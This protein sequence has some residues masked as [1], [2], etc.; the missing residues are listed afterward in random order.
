MSHYCR[1]C[2]ALK[3]QIEIKDEV[4]RSKDERIIRLQ[5]SLIQIQ[6]DLIKVLKVVNG[7]DDSQKEFSISEVPINATS[8]IPINT[9]ETVTSQS[10]FDVDESDNEPEWHLSNLNLSNLKKE[11]EFRVYVGHINDASKKRIKKVLEENFGRVLEVEM[12]INRNCAFATFATRE[13]YNSAV[14]QGFINVDGNDCCIEQPRPRNNE[15][16]PRA[17]NNEDDN[18]GRMIDVVE[19]DSELEWYQPNLK[20]EREFRVYVGHIND[21]SKKRIKK[22][23]EDNF[24]RVLEV[25]MIINRNC[26]FATFATRESYN[27]A[28]NQGFINVDGNDCCIEQPRPRNNEEQSKPRNNEYDNKGRRRRKQI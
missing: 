27:S 18:K 10:L 7:N 2:E 12:I 22:E 24:G 25:E 16:Q 6:Q 14:N 17:R 1:N 5:E 13:S 4:I 8:I 11:R 26:A 3:R 23:L 19:S 28:V 15:E 21:A 9:N 20:K